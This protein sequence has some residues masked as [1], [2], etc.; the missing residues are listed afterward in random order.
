VRA[1]ALMAACAA[2]AV[3]APRLT[4]DE[5]WLLLAAWAVVYLLIAYRTRLAERGSRGGTPS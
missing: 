1:Y 4:V 3:A 5:Q 2:S